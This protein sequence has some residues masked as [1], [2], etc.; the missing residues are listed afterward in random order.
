MD[1]PL[2]SDHVSTSNMRLFCARALP[3]ADLT[4]AARH[5][6]DC[7]DCHRLLVS[8]LRER[9]LETPS[10]TLAPEFWLRN[11]HIDYDQL[12]EL[13][14]GKLDTAERESIDAHLKICSVCEEDVKSFLVFR[15]QIAP[16]LKM[17]Y[18]A[19]VAKPN[20]E[21]PNWWEAWRRMGWKPIY[22]AALVVVGIAIVIG[23]GV[24]LKRRATL[25]AQ[26]VPTPQI[27]P[28]STP[29]SRAD[30]FPSPPAA[31]IESPIEKPNNAETVV[32][33]N[34]RGGTI[35]VYKSGN[36]TGLDDVPAPTRDAIAR[37]L[38]SERLEQPAI[39]KELGGQEGTLRGNKNAQPFK[40][41]YPSR[42]VIISDRPNF[43]WEK[44]SGASSYRVYVND[45]TGREVARSEELPSE[46]TEWMIPNPL[47]RGKIYAWTVIEMVDGREIIS[48]G[49]AFPEMK[50]QI[51]SA[52]DLQKLSQ[53]KRTRSHLAL[54]VFYA[55]V[56]M[57]DEAEREFQ[58]LVRLNPKSKV[59]D[60]ILH[61]VRWPRSRY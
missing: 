61:D 22:A 38:S 51:L 20:R 34:D 48:P 11:E 13:A 55:R 56:G 36:V 18:P 47:K 52:S 53:L 37:V 21:K 17:H 19:V 4:M 42:T 44:A 32:T 45:P 23:V 27:S 9:R 10:F 33:L 46:R 15:E 43:K 57:I 41:T 60:K 1:E 31:P 24:M 7:S 54:G 25:Q 3:E 58:E 2:M 28:G 30:N 29:D 26:Q 35:T 14:D 59:A 49:S 5:L 16:E 6:A 8:S 50:F 12:V 39:L 40:L